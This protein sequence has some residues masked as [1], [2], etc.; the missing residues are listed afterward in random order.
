MIEQPQGG[1]SWHK[2]SLLKSVG[3]AYDSIG[4]EKHSSVN[5]RWGAMRTTGADTVVRV[6]VEF[7]VAN[8]GDL[9]LA[10]RGLLP[11]DEVRRETIQGIVD[12]GATRLVLPEGV[13]KRLGLT[14]DEA[15]SVRYA[16]GRRA[17]RRVAKGVYVKLLGRDST[18][19]ALVEPKRTTALVG[20]IVLEDLDLL[21]DCAA[22]KVVPRDPKGETFEIE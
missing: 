7:E 4:R 6:S 13:V 19:T 22:Q 3:N 15:V 20:A 17:R 14:L 2:V 16:D 10:E 9:T 11:T 18:F 8:F 21:I 5:A 1:G 12:S